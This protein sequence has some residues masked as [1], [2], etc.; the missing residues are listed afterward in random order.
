MRRRDIALIKNF[1]R[2]EKFGPEHRAPA[3]FISKRRER[4]GHVERAHGAA[5]IAFDSPQGDDKPRLNA[6][7]LPNLLQQSPVFDELLSRLVDSL[8]V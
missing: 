2:G 3:A 5:E 6:V 1:Q 4:R 8:R 7:A